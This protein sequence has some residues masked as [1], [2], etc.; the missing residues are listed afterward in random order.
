[1]EDAVPSPNS[2]EDAGPATNLDTGLLF[3]AE[4]LTAEDMEVATFVWL[5]LSFVWL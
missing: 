4:R 5:K 2:F 1:L 3:L